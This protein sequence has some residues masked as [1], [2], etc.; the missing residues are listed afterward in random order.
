MQ[1]TVLLGWRRSEI[2][3]LFQEVLVILPGGILDVVK[4]CF[5]VFNVSHLSGSSFV[6][7]SAPRLA[8]SEA[9][10]L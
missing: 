5:S 8:G 9:I 2:S 4:L 7:L 10:V 6:N 1:A 3:V